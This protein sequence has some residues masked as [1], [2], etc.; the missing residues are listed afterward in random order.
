MDTPVE[1]IPHESSGKFG[2]WQTILI[3]LATWAVSTAVNWGVLQ[4]HQ[5]DMARRQDADEAQISKQVPQSEFDTWRDEVNRH[6]DRMEE[7]LD[8]LLEQK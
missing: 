8:S 3:V 5:E 6:L 4:A 2:P 7:K 1:R